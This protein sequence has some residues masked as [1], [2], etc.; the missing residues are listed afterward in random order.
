MA[1]V[2]HA[3]LHNDGNVQSL[4]KAKYYTMTRERGDVGGARYLLENDQSWLKEACRA[5][6]SKALASVQ[7]LPNDECINN[8]ILLRNGIL[9]RMKCLS[10]NS[11]ACAYLRTITSAIAQNKSV[12]VVGKNLLGTVP[13]QGGL[14]YRQLLLNAIDN[15]PLLFHSSYRAAQTDDF[16]VYQSILY[17]LVVFTI[18]A[19]MF[20]HYFDTYDM[21]WTRRL[22]TRIGLFSLST[23]AAIFA[24]LSTN[25]GNTITT[26]VGIWLPSFLVLLYFEAFLDHTIMRPW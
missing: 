25:S 19:N 4:D 2:M 5:N 14:T 17:N 3:L 1:I 22:I 13:G 23:L 16:F 24:F 18:V 11:Q 9:D 12:N 21:T 8:R 20:V 7:P 15:A 26:V 10:Y 6:F